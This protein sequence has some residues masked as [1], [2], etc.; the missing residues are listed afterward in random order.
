MTNAEAD[1]LISTLPQPG[2]LQVFRE[3]DAIVMAGG[4]HGPH[5]INVTVSSAERL[6]VHWKGYVE[7]QGLSLGPDYTRSSSK[8]P[9][10]PTMKPGEDP[11]V[12]QWVSFPS[13]SSKS[14]WRRGQVL[15]V[16]PKRVLIAF[17]FNRERAYD[18]KK[19]LKFD[20]KT[21]HTTWRKR[22]EIR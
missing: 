17:R 8:S 20:P 18:Q 6:L 5:S 14:G 16:T 15:K 9:Q 10:A 1:A 11:L 19:G 12:G 3:G 7:D 2:G 21:A 13:K 4:R 22:M